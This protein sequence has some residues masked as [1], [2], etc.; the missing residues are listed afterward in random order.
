MVTKTWL[1]LLSVALE[2]KHVGTT[3]QFVESLNW[4]RECTHSYTR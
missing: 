1:T 4:N 2:N 3:L